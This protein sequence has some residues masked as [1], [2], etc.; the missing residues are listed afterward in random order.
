MDAKKDQ[1]R[2]LWSNHLWKYFANSQVNFPKNSSLS[3]LTAH[4]V[5]KTISNTHLQGRLNNSQNVVLFTF[6]ET[7]ISSLR[8]QNGF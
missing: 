6:A 7:S 1:D 3:E 8:D 2:D 4:F 5:E